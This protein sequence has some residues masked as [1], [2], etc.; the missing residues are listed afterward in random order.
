MNKK[1]FII[2]DEL[3]CPVVDDLT[4]YCLELQTGE[5][6]MDVE[7]MYLCSK[8]E[9]CYSCVRC[10]I[11]SYTCTTLNGIPVALTQLMSQCQLSYLSKASRASTAII[12]AKFRFFIALS[13]IDLHA[14]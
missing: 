7:A 5:W 8:H 13:D 2:S 12:H 11:Q 10:A 6:D 1:M 14:R 4:T 3:L 9:L